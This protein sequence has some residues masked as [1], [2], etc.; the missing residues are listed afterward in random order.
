MSPACCLT[1]GNTA[2][3]LISDPTAGVFHVM[4]KGYTDSAGLTLQAAY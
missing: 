3:C 1:G 4:I 2:S